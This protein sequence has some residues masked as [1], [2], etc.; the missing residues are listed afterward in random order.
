MSG[1]LAIYGWARTNRKR[2]TMTLAYFDCFSGIS[3]DMTLGAL[4]HLG[5]PPDWLKTQLGRLPLSGFDIKV[6]PVAPNGI[7]ARRVDVV[8][9]DERQ[10][11]RHYQDIVENIT[12]SPFSDK[13]KNNSLAV[14]DRIAEAEAVIH[15]CEKQAVHFHEVG[16][17]DA[18]VDIVG[19]C[20][21]VEY[22]GIDRICVS[23]LPLGSGFVHCQHGVLPVPAPATLEILKN[24]P[25]YGGGQPHEL[26]TPT[27]A[28]LAAVLADDFGPMP[29]MKAERIGYGAGSHELASQP[30]LLRIVMGTPLEAGAESA[31]ERLTVVEASVDDMNPEFFGYLMEMLF[32]DGALDVLWIPVFMKKNRPAT[33]IQVLCP[34]DRK[35]IIFKRIFNETTSLGIRH[36]DVRRIALKRGIV[37]VDTEFGSLAAKKVV[38]PRGRA[39]IVPEY[40]ECRKVARE[41]H[42]P[43]RDV[44][45]AV[46]KSA[47]KRK[48]NE[49]PDAA[50]DA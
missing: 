14:F 19:S 21:A 13:V 30:D 43:L 41:H 4:I 9:D 46:L 29:P 3:G 38:D 6:C 2:N 8:V 7:Q 32:K 18:L 33:M 42:R 39:R 37:Q 11:H 10:P 24:K 15:G 47:L 49:D 28:A 17:V 26:V 34:P 25:V 27:G 48:Q 23:P 40:E 50:A 5:V 22:L 45:E 12:R 20:L 35:D 16:A 44:Y 1:K 36:H 31:M